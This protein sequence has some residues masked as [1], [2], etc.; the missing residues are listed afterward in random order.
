MVR[1]PSNYISAG[2]LSAHQLSNEKKSMRG[3]PHHKNTHDLQ[4]TVDPK[5]VE[6]VTGNTQH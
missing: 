4:K 2:H 5:M 3:K 6:R 1:P